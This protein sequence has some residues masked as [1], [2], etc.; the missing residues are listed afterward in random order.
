MAAL[1]KN[2]DRIE[3]LEGQLRRLRQ[4]LREMLNQGVVK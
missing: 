2:V 4:E 3:Q 1:V